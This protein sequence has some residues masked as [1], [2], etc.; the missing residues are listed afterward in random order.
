MGKGGGASYRRTGRH[1]TCADS[2]L[3]VCLHKHAHAAE[4][5][6]QPLFVTQLFP[7][8]CVCVCARARQCLGEYVCACM[9]A[10]Y[11]CADVFTCERMLWRRL[12]GCSQTGSRDYF[13]EAGLWD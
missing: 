2:S 11:L 13:R 5:F 4:V 6:D 1:E 7:C 10:W 8:A 12:G 3:E 9:Q